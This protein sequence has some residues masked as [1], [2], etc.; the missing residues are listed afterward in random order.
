MIKNYEIFSIEIQEGIKN[1]FKLK[2]TKQIKLL[3]L[4]TIILN[5]INY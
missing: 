4:I 5:K 1:L 2:S 3:L